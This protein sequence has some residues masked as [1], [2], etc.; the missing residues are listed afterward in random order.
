MSATSAATTVYVAVAK[1]KGGNM[2]VLGCSFS[3]DNA[4]SVARAAIQDEQEPIRGDTIYVLLSLKGE[5]YTVDTAE[6]A[7]MRLSRQ[8]E[9][10][11]VQSS[12]EIPYLLLG[13]VRQT[14]SGFKYLFGG[15]E[16]LSVDA[17][18]AVGDGVECRL[19]KQEQVRADIL[20]IRRAVS[21]RGLA[22]SRREIRHAVVSLWDIYNKADRKILPEPRLGNCG[23]PYQRLLEYMELVKLE[24]LNL[25]SGGHIPPGSADSLRKALYVPYLTALFEN[26]AELVVGL[27][28]EERTDI[29]DIMDLCAERLD[30]IVENYD[31][32]PSAAQ[33]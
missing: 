30:D 19:T 12:E 2:D 13:E 5:I 7:Y 24:L 27:T 14:E 21:R 23:G 15:A 32:L 18:Y 33:L 25:V 26:F 1:R 10:A 16:V 3:K 17:R 4:L 20:R 9:N 28:K 31:L 29:L 11:V 6:S 8:S 22:L